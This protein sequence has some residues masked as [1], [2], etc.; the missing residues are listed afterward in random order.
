MR[1]TGLTYGFLKSPQ[2]NLL[3][4][5]SLHRVIKQDAG[6][7]DVQLPLVEPADARQEG[8]AGVLEG[9]GQT[10]T[11]DKAAEDGETAHEDKQPEPAS[12]VGDAAHMENA[13]G[14]QLGRGLAELVTEVKEHDTLGSLIARVPGRKRP[15]AARNETRLGNSEQE[16]GRDEGAIAVLESLKGRNEAEQ[17]EL[18]SKPL[19]RPDAVQDHVGWDLKEHDAQRQHLLANVELVLCDPDILHELV[20]DSISDVATVELCDKSSSA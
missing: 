10:E 20:S 12:L 4:L 11:E 16:S 13:V 7:E 5:L 17:E 14:E 18:Q 9:I 19:S 8:T 3:L 2:S 15:Q 1:G 6:L